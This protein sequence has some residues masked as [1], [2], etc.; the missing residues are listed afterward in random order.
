M[1]VKQG[2]LDFSE[3]K[4]KKKETARVEITEQ[5]RKDRRKHAITSMGFDVISV[6]LEI[7]QQEKK[8]IK[9]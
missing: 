1:P 6:F 7:N 8:K 5:I 4:K 2:S 3:K 9:R